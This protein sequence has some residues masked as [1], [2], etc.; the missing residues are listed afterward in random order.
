M[1][2]VFARRSPP[3]GDAKPDWWIIAEV[4]RC[5]GTTV[6]FAYESASEVFDELCAL[7]PIYHG[8][9][10]ERIDA[11]QLHWP[12]P[13]K[14]HPGTPF[15]H[16]GE[17]P[18]GRG[19]LQCVEYVPPAEVP[20]DEYPWFLTT[21]RRLATY[22]TNTMT[23]RAKGLNILAPNEWLEMHPMDAE[24]LG[25]RTKD[26]VKVLSRRGEVLTRVKVTK[27]SPPG[28]MFMSFAFP[29]ETPT[30]LITNPEAD[31]ITE[32]PELKVAAIRVEKTEAPDLANY[33]PVFA[34]KNGH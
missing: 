10:Y 1:C 32:T 31:P 15:L 17:F 16:E 2:N 34:A 5:V 27:A 25:V 28:T 23:G 22:H 26:W 33:D 14:D 13:T 3:P 19:M 21:G 6:N 7:S 4:A 11:G 20:D 30:N 18:R 12:V 24:E 8:L 9:S 29:E